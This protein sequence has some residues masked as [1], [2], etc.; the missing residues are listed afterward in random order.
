MRF[1]I[2]YHKELPMQRNSHSNKNN[3]QQHFKIQ[4]K[5][6]KLRTGIEIQKPKNEFKLQKCKSKLTL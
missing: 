3:F 6:S 4:P 5:F 1:K 2:N